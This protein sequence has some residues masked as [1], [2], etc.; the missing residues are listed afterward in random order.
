M[1][2][3]DSEPMEEEFPMVAAIEPMS[4]DPFIIVRKTTSKRSNIQDIQAQNRPNPSLLKRKAR[5]RRQS[6]RSQSDLI[7]NWTNTAPSKE[8]IPTVTSRTVL[9]CM[10]SVIDTL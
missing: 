4:D 3:E 6:P 8:S 10:K 1:K 2:R 5:H 9:K 7:H